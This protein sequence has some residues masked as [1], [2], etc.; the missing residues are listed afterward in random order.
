MGQLDRHLGFTCEASKFPGRA[1]LRGQLGQRTHFLSRPGDN[2]GELDDDNDDDNAP[3]LVLVHQ[4]HQPRQPK[5]LQARHLRWRSPNS[6]NLLLS[7]QYT[8]IHHIT[9]IY[10]H[11][12]TQSHST[13]SFTYSV[14]LTSWLFG[15]YSGSENLVSRPTRWSL[16]YWYL[17]VYV[18]DHLYLYH[19][20]FQI[21]VTEK[22]STAMCYREPDVVRIRNGIALVQ[23]FNWKWF[24]SRFTINPAE[25]EEFCFLIDPIYVA[26]SWLVEMEWDYNCSDEFC[27]ESSNVNRTDSSQSTLTPDICHFRHINIPKRY[28]IRKH[29]TEGPVRVTLP[30]TQVMSIS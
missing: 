5:H 15:S 9:F 24:I 21:Q 16:W 8:L 23:S 10:L 11:R 1:L 19:L 14:S 27:L 13:F 28:T 17:D 3:V 20:F 30:P 18:Y 26:W 7:N 4:H 22:Y 25:K 29:W 6:R 2:D 12:C